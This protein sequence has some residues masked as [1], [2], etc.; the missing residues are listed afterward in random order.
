MPLADLSF[1]YSNRVRPA[2]RR[3]LSSSSQ[4]CPAGTSVYLLKANLLCGLGMR[5][6]GI[7]RDG[8]IDEL[9]KDKVAVRFALQEAHCEVEGAR[10]TRS[11][12]EVIRLVRLAY[13]RKIY[14]MH[15]RRDAFITKRPLGCRQYTLGSVV[16]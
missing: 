13:R 1:K 7:G 5:E 16:A 9:A 14:F 4:P 11:R 3:S 8:S 10:R 12:T 6:Y 15:R 2:S